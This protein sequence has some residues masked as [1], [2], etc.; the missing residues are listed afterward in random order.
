MPIVI[1]EK[2]KKGDYIVNRSAGDMAVFDKI[3]KKGFMSFKIYYGSMFSHVK[4]KDYTLYSYYQK[5]F[6]ICNE[7]EKAIFDYIIEDYNKN[8]DK[9][10][11]TM[12][13]KVDTEMKRFKSL[14]DAVVKACSKNG[15]N[16]NTM[17]DVDGKYHA[18]FYAKGDDPKLA[19]LMKAFDKIGLVDRHSRI[20][21]MHHYGA[22]EPIEVPE[23][24]KRTR[25]KKAE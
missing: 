8:P 17:I 1:E 14:D 5:F 15:F 9:Y 2:F 11:L 20:T 21:N 13:D 18:V 3:D 19:K 23:K 4:S 12:S 7:E 10:E 24:P 6:D 22:D 25:K 16:V